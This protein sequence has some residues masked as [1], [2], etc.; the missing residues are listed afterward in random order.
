MPPRSK[1]KL[2]LEAARAKKVA[3]LG[4]SSER[5]DESSRREEGH[6]SGVERRG[7]SSASR[8]RDETSVS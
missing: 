3:K 1:R 2:Q 5:R 8:M 6:G 4:E 7:E